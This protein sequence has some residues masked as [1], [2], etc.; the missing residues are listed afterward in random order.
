M[1]RKTGHKKNIISVKGREQQVIDSVHSS[2]R[3]DLEK[4][5]KEY[6]DIFPE[7]LP[8]G[9]P[10]KRKCSIRLKS[11]QALNLPIATI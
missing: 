3:K 2:Y 11:T 1:N 8:K 9:V 7:K 10:P 6:Q 5:I 4:V